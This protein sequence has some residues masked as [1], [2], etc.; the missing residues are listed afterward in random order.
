MNRTHRTT[1]G[2]ELPLLNLRGKEYLEVKYRVVW[3][4]EE[5]PDWT[6]ETEY[7]KVSNDSAW[8]KASIKDAAGRLIATSHKFENK[9]GFP[10]FLEK[11]ETGAIG[12][13]LALIGYGTQFCADELDEGHRVVDSPVAPRP[14]KSTTSETDPGDFVISFGNKYKGKKIKEVKEDVL[15][16]FLLWCEREASKK[17]TTLSHEAMLLKINFLKFMGPNYAFPGAG[18]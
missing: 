6:I 5:H 17:N 14:Q 8:A 10:D 3:F 9:E 4:R 1:K 12:R 13:A 18:S 16:G 7:L 2:T 15:E 11:S